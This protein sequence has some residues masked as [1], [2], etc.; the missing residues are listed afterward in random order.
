MA[1]YT[2]RNAHHRVLSDIEFTK[3][4]YARAL[5]NAFLGIDEDLRRRTH[6]SHAR[7]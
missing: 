5:E 2:G 6:S 1:E 7:A 4:N 3:G